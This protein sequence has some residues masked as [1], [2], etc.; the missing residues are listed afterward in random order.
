[1][2]KNNNKSWY[3]VIIA[4]FVIWFLLTLTSSI[5]KLVLV[6][7]NDSRW[8]YN[9]L[10]TYYATKGAWELV[11]LKIK[12]N[13]Y[14]YYEK[15][16]LDKSNPISNILNKDLEDNPLISYDINSKV[17]KY[18]WELKPLSY[19]VIPLF[20]LENAS[21]WVIVNMDLSI[22]DWDI[23]DLSWNIITS[24]WWL[25]GVWWFTSLNEWFLKQLDSVW[26]FVIENKTIWAFLEENKINSNYLVILNSSDTSTIKYNLDWK[27][28]FFTKP[29]TDIA[30]SSKLWSYKQNISIKY[31]NTD[32]L[33]M[34]KYSIY[35]D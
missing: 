34:L 11:M 8:V 16:D 9:Y 31:D 29:R 19:D 33:G 15:I 12:E 14:G 6:E 22:S 18:D 30:V 25:S 32:Y 13:W 1:M 4:I 26:D 28:G 27:W 2:L 7:L 21:S 23:N 35:N 20:Y 17:E 3:S 24:N 10:K 5:L